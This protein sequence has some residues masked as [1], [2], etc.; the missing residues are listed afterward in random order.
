MDDASIPRT[1]R[2]LLLKLNTEIGNLS[3]AIDGLGNKLVDI[4][5]KRIGGLDKRVLALENWK[6]QITGA[7]RLVLV[8]WSVVTALGLIGLV[9]SYIK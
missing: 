1:D 5:E 8:I 7:W 9:K 6:Q 4:E 2:E 3:R